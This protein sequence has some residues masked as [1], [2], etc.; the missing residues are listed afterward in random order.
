MTKKVSE[1]TPAE[2]QRTFPIIVEEHNACYRGWYEAERER[3]LN[4]VCVHDVARINHIGSTAVEGLSAKPII[5]ILLEMDGCCDVTGLLDGLR[6]IG[7]GI[8]ILTRSDD[9][10]RLLLGKGMSA[11]GY[12]ERVYLLHVRYIGDWGELYFR[13]LL[14]ANAAVRAEYGALK[15]KILDDIEKGIIERMPGGKPNGYSQA[16]VAFVQKYTDAARLEYAGRY[17]PWPHQA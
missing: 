6:T 17:R 4:A 15:A 2:W 13:D 3:I 16:K 12:A 7:Y 8:E 10:V 11:D 5:D 9:P 1:L 14:R